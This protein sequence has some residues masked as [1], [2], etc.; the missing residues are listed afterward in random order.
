MERV[1]HCPF[2]ELS[3]LLPEVVA[4]SIGTQG[5]RMAPLLRWPVAQN[6]FTEPPRQSRSTPPLVVPWCLTW[7]VTAD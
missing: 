2:K 5:F 6:D 7:T 4:A 3:L 1:S